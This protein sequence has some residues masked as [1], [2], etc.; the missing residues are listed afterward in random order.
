MI[1]AFE[2]KRISLDSEA[3]IDK[4]LND[5]SECITVAAHKGERSINYFTDRCSWRNDSY[6]KDKANT[7]FVNRIINKLTI[8]GYSASISKGAPYRSPSG[9]ED[10]ADVY[11]LFLFI[12][13]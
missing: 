2:A 8:N 4:V 6:D 10:D 3:E 12:R 11:N 9:S 7:P 5:I 13:W 1:K